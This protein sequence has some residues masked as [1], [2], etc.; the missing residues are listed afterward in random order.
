MRLERQCC[1]RLRA[2]ERL[3]Q[4]QNAGMSPRGALAMLVLGLAATSVAGAGRSGSGRELLQSG[5]SCFPQ[6]PGCMARR[7]TTRILDSA[8]TYVCLRCQR[9]LVPVRGSDGRSVVQCSEC[10]APAGC[11]CACPTPPGHNVPDCAAAAAGQQ[12]PL[13]AVS[14][15]AAQGCAPHIGSCPRCPALLCPALLCSALPCSALRPLLAVCAAGSH[16]MSGANNAKNCTACATGSY[17]PGGSKRA[18]LPTDEMGT[19][20]PCGAGLTTKSAK[21]SRPEDCGAGG[22]ARL[23][24]RPLQ[25]R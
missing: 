3:L 19:A 4:L 23:L 5:V 14:S 15:P 7:C 6:I 16:M 24:L 18:R 25:A 12:R 13:P 17:C 10:A 9:G 22:I 2:S 1:H 11:A 8:E 21:S 20:K